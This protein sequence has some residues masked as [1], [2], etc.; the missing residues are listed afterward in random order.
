MFVPVDDSLIAGP[1]AGL[2]RLDA[3][4]SS[5]TRARPDGVLGFVGFF[6]NYATE[7]LEISAILNITASTTRSVHT[8]KR[9]VGSVVDAM[10]LGTE[11]VAVHVNVTS[12]YEGDMLRLLGTVAG[13]C[14]RYGVPLMGIMYAR[15][16]KE[17]GDENYEELRTQQPKRYAELLSHVCRIGAELGADILKTQYTGDAESFRRV[18]DA[19]APVPVVIAGGPVAPAK[20]VFRMAIDAVSAGA[21]GVS[22]GRN[23]FSRSD[24]AK[25]IEALKLLVHNGASLEA[26]MRHVDSR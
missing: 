19:C 22:F 17:D 25:W 21:A 16:E 12:R 2:Q 13:E 10:T 7:L 23:V 4:V 9:R 18:V 15:T 6:R 20:Q 3:I 5:I 1:V 24:P 14:D 8:Y 11:A 26:A